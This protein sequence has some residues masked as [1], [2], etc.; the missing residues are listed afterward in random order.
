MFGSSLSPV[1][2]GRAHVLFVLFVF[3]CVW[4]CQKWTIQ[5]NWQHL[6]HKRWRKNT[7]QYVFD[8]TVLQINTNNVNKT[9]NEDDM[10][11]NACLDYMWK[12]EYQM[13]YK[14]MSGSGDIYTPKRENKW[15][16][17][18]VVLV[19]TTWIISNMID[20]VLP[21]TL[22]VSRCYISRFKGRWFC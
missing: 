16:F 17:P 21:Y 8:T 19:W 15:A 10:K 9:W 5:T 11:T 13:P 7:T 14:K 18:N 12:Q 6:G 1:V 2:C 3:V 4:W 22:S 20:I